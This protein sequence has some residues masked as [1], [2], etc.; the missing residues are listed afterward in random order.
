MAANKQSGF[1]LIEALVAILVIALG[2]L[3]LAGM[4][5]RMQ[6]AEF[7]S[8]QRT[9][10]LILLYDMADRL[11]AHRTAAKD[12]FAFTTNV[13]GGAPVVG[14][15]ANPPAG[16]ASPG[17]AADNA[18]ADAAIAEW[19]ALLEGAAETSSGTRVGALLGGRGCVS[20]DAA[21]E[22]TNPT[23]G[24]V[25]AGT[26]LFTLT[27]AWQGM[28]PVAQPVG[29]PTCG[30]GSYGA[31]DTVRRAISTTVRLGYLKP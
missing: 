25:L 30:T 9:Q 18:E 29:Y 6:Q 16:C 2:L 15:G 21:S 5:V 12:C 27:V 20:Y 28:S 8:Y 10:A 31:D 17:S 23:T 1:T 4:Q 19:D 11:N 26:G 7:E 24:V 14:T 3:G 13:A 22:V